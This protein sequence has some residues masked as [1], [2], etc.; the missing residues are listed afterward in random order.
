MGV[1]ATRADPKKSLLP[2][3]QVSK[4]LTMMLAVH[5]GEEVAAILQAILTHPTERFQDGASVMLH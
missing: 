4:C 5:L 2:L 1:H 3:C